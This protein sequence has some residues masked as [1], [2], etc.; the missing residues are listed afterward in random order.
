MK[1]G[2]I[3]QYLAL[4]AVG[5]NPLQLSMPRIEHLSGR[6]SKWRTEVSLLPNIFRLSL[7]ENH[8]SESLAFFL[9]DISAW[10]CRSIIKQL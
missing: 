10:C 1:V 8:A 9:L 3:Q 2:Q 4:L 7:F 5:I 6:N